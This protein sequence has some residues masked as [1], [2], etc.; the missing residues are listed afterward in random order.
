MKPEKAPGYW[1]TRILF[2]VAATATAIAV[3]VAVW[4]A[5]WAPPT[6]SGDGASVF[7]LPNRIVVPVLAV[8]VALAGFIWTTKIIRGPRDEPPPWRFRDR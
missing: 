8:G 7:G 1:P 6:V 5:F 4:S 3:V 2:A